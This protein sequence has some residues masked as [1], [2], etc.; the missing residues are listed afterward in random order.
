MHMLP[1]ENWKLGLAT[2]A[3]LATFSLAPSARA[4]SAYTNHAG[5]AVSGFPVALDARTVTL[6]NDTETLTLP[7]S[8]FPDEERRRIA[9][10]FG[11]PVLP[12]RLQRAVDACER[13]CERA[14]RRAALG[15]CSQAEADDYCVRARA[16]LDAALSRT[17][18]LPSSSPLP[19]VHVLP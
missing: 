3:T 8:I 14:Q 4:Q 5:Y 9:A 1:I 2:L 17:N 16:A 10:D 7:L 6:S 18:G 15:L 12:T 19:T 11:T 13:S